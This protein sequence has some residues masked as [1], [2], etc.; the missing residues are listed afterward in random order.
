SPAV[1]RRPLTLAAVPTTCHTTHV[2]VCPDGSAAPLH[3]VREGADRCARRS[4]HL[5]PSSLAPE[6]GPTYRRFSD[7]TRTCPEVVAASGLV[8]AVGC[9]RHGAFGLRGAST[10]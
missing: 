4:V 6:I 2:R 7:A 1:R 10:S 5:P 8:A 3:R 9:A